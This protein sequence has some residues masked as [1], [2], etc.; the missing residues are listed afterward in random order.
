[1]S[2]VGSEQWMY[3]AGAEFYDFPIE[4]SLRFNNPDQP[5]LTRSVT[6]NRKT[7]T[8]N[9]WVKRANL[10]RYWLYG[11]YSNSANTANLTFE[12][13]GT[14]SFYDFLSGDRFRLRTS[15][16]FRDV[17]TYYCITLSVDTTQSTASDRV[18][19]FINGVQET[20]FSTATYPSQNLDLKFGGGGTHAIGTEGTNNRLWWDGYLA[21]WNLIDGT[22]LDPTS[23]GEFKSGIFIPKD[24]SGLTFGS[25]GYRLQFGD[26]AAIG[27]DTSGNTNDWTVNNL[28]ASD[29][30]LDSPTNNWCVLNS[31]NKSSNPVY[32]EGNLKVSTSSTVEAVCPATFGVSSGKWYFEYVHLSS[33]ATVVGIV[34]QD[35]PL[36]AWA[37][38]SGTEW[39]A[40]NAIGQFQSNTG[41]TPSNTSAFSN[42]DIIGA[43]LDLDANEVEFFV[44]GSSVGKITG[45][46][47]DVLY[48]PFIGD[49]GTLSGRDLDGVSNFGQDSTFAGA[50]TAGG[51]A[52]ANGYGSFKYAPPT[53][54][55]ALCSANLP[56]GAI[57]TLAD[58][59]P[60]DY[61]S[62][63]T[64][65]GTGSSNSV[66]VGFEPSLTWLKN[67][68]AAYSH[69]LVD[70]VRGKIGSDSSFARLAS[71]LTN[72]EATPGGDDGL[73]SFDSDGFTVLGDESYNSSGQSMVA[74]NWKANGSGVSN[75][76]GSITSTV[77]VGATSQQNW[78]SIVGYTGDGTVASGSNVGHGLGRKPDA[79]IVKDRSAAYNW[80]AW[81]NSFTGSQVI[82]P[83]LTNARNSDANVWSATEPTSSVF[84]VGNG[85][86]NASS[87]NYIAYCFAN[88]EGLCKVG[89]YTGNGSADGVFVYTGFRPAWV[90]IKRTDAAN[91]WP[92]QDSVRNDFNAVDKTLYADLSNSE[93][94]LDRMDF[95]SNGFKLRNTYLENNA[96]GGTYIYLAI[97]EQP[98]KYANAR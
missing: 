37:P 55:L 33:D 16:V 82:Y 94:D 58:E 39:A 64:F 52:D 63:V 24:T 96:S 95:L 40:L 47:S 6:H 27:D 41:T 31:V 11:V 28:V 43:A 19:M 25:G 83:N 53:D 5:R 69:Q 32:S 2:I 72:A 80:N 92:I 20:S 3:S 30:V 61:F 48:F 13:D 54:A 42:N 88:A 59:T 89:S 93:S 76:D 29:V 78:F 49:R 85:E 77:S 45:I 18:K 44:N 26:S 8:I 65:T 17:G 84:Y 98:F 74:W 62:T 36:A 81:F 15:R 35:V 1:M 51:N 14:L 46:T 10:G 70:Q 21:D 60:E 50:T 86:V 71:N 73:T 79:I 23:F 90:M 7:F 91:D 97:A 68:S 34:T 38:S 12:S 56:S 75:T 9:F 87:N 22:A 67:R 57:D 4:Q 66:T